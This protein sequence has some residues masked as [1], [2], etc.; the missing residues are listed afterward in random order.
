MTPATEPTVELVLPCLDEAESLPRLLAGVPHGWRVLVVDNG[1]SDGTA[2]VARR[3]GARVVVEPRRGYGSA[4]HTGIAS[5]TGDV[6]VVIDGDGSVSPQDVRALVSDVVTGRA[7]LACGTRDPQPGAWSWHARLGNR[8]L[9]GLMSRRTGVRL[10]DIA[11]VRVARR[12]DLLA[13][14]VTDRRCGYPLE[15]L[16]RASAAGWRVVERPV[17]YRPRTG[18]RSKVSGTLRGTVH[19]ARDFAAVLAR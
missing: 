11:P 4:V 6:V 16:L 13:L 1:S 19:V 2:E 18:G 10:H 7:D 3:A 14:G 12:V 5:A 17:P 15:T 9:A 8:F